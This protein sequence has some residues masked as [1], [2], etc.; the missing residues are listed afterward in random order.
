METH[1][2]SVIVSEERHS[3]SGVEGPLSLEPQSDLYR[4]FSPQVIAFSMPEIDLG[5]RVE[6]F[7]SRTPYRLSAL[8]SVLSAV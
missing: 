3:P 1:D 5:R 8:L 6:V 2:S 7:S 4:E